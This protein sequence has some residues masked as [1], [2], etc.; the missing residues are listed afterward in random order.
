MS[1]DSQ[2]TPDA[3]S[4]AFVWLLVAIG[5]SAIAWFIGIP[6]L[7]SIGWILLALQ[8]GELQTS[9]ASPDQRHRLDVH[10]AGPLV[11]PYAPHTIDLVVRTAA[12]RPLVRYSTSLKNDGAHLSDRAIQVQWV[13]S[14]TAHICLRGEEQPP[15]GF[16]TQILA[17]SA[18]TVQPHPAACPPPASP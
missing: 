15:T 8:P 16:Q 3:V 17:D 5:G 10:A 4:P 11:H 1:L 13:D 9:V 12:G 14:N 2:P 6:L 18:P 7:L